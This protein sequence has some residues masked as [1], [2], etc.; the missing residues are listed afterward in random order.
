MHTE[1]QIK[2]IKHLLNDKSLSFIIG[3]GF[4]KNMS[5]KFV[6]WGGLLKP[7]IQEMYHLDDEIDIKH[8]IEEIGYI[9]I[10]QE[11]VRR[12]GYHEAIDVYIEQ[13]T[14]IISIQGNSENA[15]APEYLVT[16][17]DEVL[18]RA[19]VTC[20]KLLFELDAKY[21]STFNYD[22]CLDIIGKT[23]QAQNLLIEIRNN[24]NKLEAL[25]RYKEKLGHY[26]DKQNNTK[27]KKEAKEV[28]AVKETTPTDDY[29]NLI[30]NFNR[31]YSTLNL[32][33]D[34]ISLL[35]DN[36]RKIE[37]EI[38]RIKAQISSLQK[39]RN[40]VYQLI[41]SSEMLSL[42]DGKKS[43]FKLH[44]SIRLDK[45]ALF[46]FD[47]DSHCNY[48]ITSEDYKEYPIKH[49]PFVD[50]MKISLLK[51][52]FCIIGFSCDDPNFLSWMSW[53]KEVVDKNTEIR[54]ELSQKNSARFFYIHSATE[55]LSEEK[56]CY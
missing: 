41:S 46:G 49:E 12:K 36:Y 11:F 23:R 33:A 1:Q 53:V 24:Q 30:N 20:H 6:D 26:T 55:P 7:I 4:S 51:G 56:N 21:I 32:I 38:G 45:N 2:R 10:A 18:D 47:G 39:Q 35:S 29:N 3:A 8:K 54:N 44:G 14:P 31:E 25:E 40:S 27:E 9:E 19:D 34:D 37:T 15:D 5:D 50:Y 13:H 17:N 28:S 22:N 16:L 42:T 48:I 43:I 52:A